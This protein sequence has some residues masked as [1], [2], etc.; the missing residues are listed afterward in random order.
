MMVGVTGVSVMPIC[1]STGE[2]CKLGAC[3]AFGGRRG[4]DEGEG[5]SYTYVV[6]R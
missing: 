3:W 5:W 1:F 6:E 2:F 4:V